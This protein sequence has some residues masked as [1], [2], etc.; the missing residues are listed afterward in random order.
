[1][2]SDDAHDIGAHNN[3]AQFIKLHAYMRTDVS[4][5]IKHNSLS[6]KPLMPFLKLTNIEKMKA[7]SRPMFNNSEKP[8]G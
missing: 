2:H 1:M 7:I 3:C 5:L 4:F 6:F 8:N